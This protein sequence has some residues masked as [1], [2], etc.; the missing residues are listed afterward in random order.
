MRKR[1]EASAEFRRGE[2]ELN[3]REATFKA[4]AVALMWVLIAYALT[5]CASG[6]KVPAEVLI[7]VDNSPR[8]VMPECVFV[9]APAPGSTPQE[10]AR[11]AAM[12]L[13][14]QQACIDALRAAL[15]P[16]MK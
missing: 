9:A 2:H 7:P 8:A 4:W 13:D 16:Y 1:G 6:P 15:V 10:V 11:A 12:R 3:A 5:G 14:A